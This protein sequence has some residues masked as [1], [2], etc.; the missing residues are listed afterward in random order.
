MCL[1]LHKAMINDRKNQLVHGDQ[2]KRKLRTTTQTLAWMA[3]GFFGIISL[4]S[5]SSSIPTASDTKYIPEFHQKYFNK[6]IDEI[7]RDQLSLYVDCSKCISLGQNSPF[8]QALVPSWTDATRKYYSIEGNKILQHQ[9]DSTFLLLRNINETDYADLKTA[10]ERMANENNESVLLTDGEYFQPS[11]AKGNINNPYMANALKT[12][13]KKGHDVYILSE[14]YVEPYKGQNFN[15]KRFYILFTDWRL[16]GNIYERIMQTVNLDQFPQVEVFHLS[17][18]HPQLMSKNAQTTEPNQHLN[19]KVSPGI[20]DYEVQ[21]WEIDWKDG[22]E[23]LIVNAVNPNTGEPLPD[24]E[25]F[26][27]GWRIDRNSFGGYRI[28][29]VSAKVYN[30]NQEYFDFYCAKDGKQKPTPKI[31]P[32][33][34]ENFVK[35]N[36]K[37]FSDHGKIN[38]HFDTQN[39]YPDPVLNGSP[40]NYFK[41]DICVSQVEPMFAQHKPMFTFDSIDMP[42]NQNVSVAASVE[43]CL[44]DPDIKAMI[45]TC[46]VY[47]IYVKSNER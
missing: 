42:G 44:T 23:P 35:I 47:T 37:E 21:D 12:W 11:I 8:F 9:P 15:K 5:C 20:G 32:A 14:P 7:S 30:I 28:T 25:P 40:Y 39:Y 19:A 34:C 38:L 26:I 6:G 2:L 31:Q 45:S 46:P 16:K 13:L 1:I 33:E 27:S 43:Q 10:A 36:P 3:A 24:G 4:N 29:D 41:I 18:D 22:I 17:A